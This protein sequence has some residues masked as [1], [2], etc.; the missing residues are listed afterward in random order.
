MSRFYR[1]CRDK[2]RLSRF[3]RFVQTFQDLLRYLNIIKTFEVLQAQKSWQIE[4][5]RSRNMIKLTNSWSRLKQTVKICQKLHV[6]TDFSILIKNFGTG[7]W[8]QDKIEI[9]QRQDFLDC[10]DLLFASV[11]IETL[12]WDH[13]ETNQDP[14]A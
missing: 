5:S 1:D 12:D 13:V 14:Q 9:S 11:E 8:C 4:K 10:R 6:S 2:L 3:S 7:R